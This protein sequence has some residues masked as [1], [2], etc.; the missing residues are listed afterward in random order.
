[1]AK[2][3]R[4][5]SKLNR[6]TSAKKIKSIQSMKD[7]GSVKKKQE[8]S[9]QKSLASR[10]TNSEESFHK[11]KRLYNNINH[12]FLIRVND[13]Y[14]Q[15]SAGTQNPYL[16]EVHNMVREIDGFEDE[17]KKSPER[18]AKKVASK[19]I[20]DN[21]KPSKE[22]MWQNSDKDDSSLDSAEKH[23]GDA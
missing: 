15:Q 6:G 2:I 20:K 21:M 7:L 1:V 3:N 4:T 9:T 23:K 22:M 16:F 14:F 8:F 11:E 12:E 5:P 17:P 18:L 19:V 10:E 13:L